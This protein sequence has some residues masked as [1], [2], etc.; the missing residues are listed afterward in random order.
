[1]E[2]GVEVQDRLGLVS[3]A[4]RMCLMKV[5][6][7]ERPDSF[8]SAGSSSIDGTSALTPGIDRQSRT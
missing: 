4:G 3:C 6:S 7:A 5:Q 1:M 8:G 2:E